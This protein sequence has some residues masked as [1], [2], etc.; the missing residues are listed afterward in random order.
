MQIVI[1]AGGAGTRLWPI[2]TKQKPK[3]FVDILGEKSL[4]KRVYDNVVSEFS[5]NDVW[6]LGVEEYKDLIIE[7]LP[8][9]FNKEQ[10]ILQPYN[11]DTYPALCVA[12]AMIAHKKGVDEPIMLLPCDDYLPNYRSIK[13]LLK[14][15]KS[16]KNSLNEGKFDV[17]IA[18][19]QPT[20]ANTNYGYVKVKLEDKFNSFKNPVKVLEFKEKPDLKTAKEYVETGEYLWHKFNPSFIPKNF[21]QGLQT[22]DEKA[23]KTIQ[24]IIKKGSYTLEEFESFEKTALDYALLEKS[25]NLGVMGLDIEWE[26]LGNW[27]LVEKYLPNIDPND[28]QRIEVDARG[29]KILGFNNK[30]VGFVGVNNLLLVESEAGVLIM[31]TRDIENIKKVSEKFSK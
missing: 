9:Y 11:R 24:N 8:D 3:Q 20:Y 31:D 17:V 28:P 10:I 19:V 1:T 22:I 16:I 29:N 23:Y 18:G 12:T 13:N 6:V 27:S 21:L 5:P 14:A 15:I 25:K 2:S 30:K 7:E 4:F 26:D